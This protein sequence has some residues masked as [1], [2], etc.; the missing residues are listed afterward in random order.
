[1][2]AS[3]EREAFKARPMW[4]WTYLLTGATVGWIIS[5]MA[6]VFAGKANAGAILVGVM[7]AV[8]WVV[9]GVAALC[10]AIEAAIAREGE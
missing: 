3:T 4:A 2:T 9:R 10:A 8:L 6:L 1:M 5:T 7:V